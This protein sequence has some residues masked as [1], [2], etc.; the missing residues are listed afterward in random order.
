MFVYVP[1]RVVWMWFWCGV[2]NVLSFD[3]SIYAFE[4]EA[5]KL[6][7]KEFDVSAAHCV[8]WRLC[9]SCRLWLGSRADTSRAINCSG[10]VLK[11]NV[12]VYSSMTYLSS[13]LISDELQSSQSQAELEFLEFY[14]ILFYHELNERNRSLLNLTSLIKYSS[15][16]SLGE[17]PIL[18]AISK[19][20]NKSSS[21][22][23]LA[24]SLRILCMLCNL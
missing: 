6:W 21:V 2:L 10:F 5:W 24:L 14:S 12:R 8:V 18:N 22:H 11:H 15:I 16:D 1:M 20:L 9:A 13:E 17:K 7:F 4:V 19:E 3:H 23:L